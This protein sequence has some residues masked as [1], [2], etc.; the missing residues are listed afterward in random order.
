MK[1]KLLILFGTRAE[2]IKLAPIVREFQ[3]RGLRD[4]L[5]IVSSGQHQTLVH[6]DLIYF[7]IQ[8]DHQFSL[9]RDSDSLLQLQGQLLLELQAMHM[10]LQEQAVCISAVI[11]HGDTCTTFCAAQYAFYENIPFV[12]I[13]AG[14]R[15][16]DFAEPFPE[17][18]YR[19]TISTI[20]AVHC[21]PTAI[22][23][24]NLLAEGVAAEA[25]LVTGNTAIDN[26]SKLDFGESASQILQ[27][28]TVIVTIHRRENI[29][30]HLPEII[31]QVAAY[32]A[33]NPDMTFVWI[34]NPGYK[35]EQHLP[36]GIP[37]LQLISPVAFAQM[38]EW[39]ATAQ[40]VI[41]DS[42][43]LQEEASFLRIPTLLFR[44]KTERLEGIEAGIAKYIGAEMQNLRQILDEFQQVDWTRGH[45][46]YG[47][48]KAAEMIVDAILE[49]FGRG[50]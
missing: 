37:N 38:L 16:H 18:Y 1:N 9:Q 13:E 12:H 35:I 17:E 20:A 8:L 31:A 25:I 42:G 2:L 49:R 43:G 3:R 45:K 5:H 14:L 6:E 26:L 50:V 32:C 28:A 48:G 19:K 46:L 10:Q 7:E 44:K 21:A 36:T 22:A 33:Q 40:L 4:L 41:T 15:T 29:R 24:E 39:Y 11:A 47:D 34:D 23:R 30:L 27:A